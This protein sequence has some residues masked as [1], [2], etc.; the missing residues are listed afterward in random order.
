MHAEKAFYETDFAIV[1][2]PSGF[3]ES[4]IQ[5]ANKLNVLLVDPASLDVLENIL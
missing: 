1:V 4:A 3:T 2:S 5:L